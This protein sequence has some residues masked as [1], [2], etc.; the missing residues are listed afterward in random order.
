MYCLIVFDCL[1]INLLYL[2]TI[3]SHIQPQ[4]K[5]DELGNYKYSDDMRRYTNNLK[6]N[7]LTVINQV[8]LSSK[9]DDRI[10][11]PYCE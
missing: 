2:T 1:W 4:K 6:I 5:I 8:K 11:D 10:I 3:L 7:S 9:G